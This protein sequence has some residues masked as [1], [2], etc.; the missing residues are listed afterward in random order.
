MRCRCS[1]S[2]SLL[3]SNTAGPA[4]HHCFAGQT[5]IAFGTFIE[6]TRFPRIKADK[7]FPFLA[8]RFLL[9]H[10]DDILRGG[11]SDGK[12]LRDK[13]KVLGTEITIS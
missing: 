8:H 10:V 11:F 13:H 12:L 1:R 5:L 6:R 4:R 7:A 2:Y 3:A 9:F